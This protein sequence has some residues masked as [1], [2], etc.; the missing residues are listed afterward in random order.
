[1]MQKIQ[2]AVLGSS[3]AIC[4]KK[5][6]EMA[7]I[8]GAELA[9]RGCITIT[10]G[11]M[12]VMEAALTG[13]KKAGGLTVGIIPWESIRK[14]NKY[15]DVTIATGLGWSRD[16]INVNSCDGAIIV[17]GGAGTLNEATYGYI[18]EKPMVAIKPSGGIAGQIAGKHLDVRKTAKIETANEPLEA[19]SKL[20]K[21]IEKKRKEKTILSAFDKDILHLEDKKDWDK[22]I[23]EIE[24]RK[25]NKK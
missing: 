7:E 6:Y 8:I 23:K 20:L 21:L 5:A 12:G 1:M 24:K 11:G 15:A 25:K 9:K 18:R 13:A 4:T 22:I 10:G 14:V 17:H 16:A 19:V 2:V 3:K